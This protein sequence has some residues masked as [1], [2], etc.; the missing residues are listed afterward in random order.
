MKIKLKPLQPQ[1]IEPVLTLLEA[2]HLE[3][4][5]EARGHSFDAKSV[6]LNLVQ[7]SRAPRAWLRVA[8]MGAQRV[9]VG[10]LML[11]PS[12][13]D[14]RNLQAVELTWHSDPKLAPA[15]RCRI[16]RAIYDGME[17]WARS[18]RAFT[19]HFSIT[20]EADGVQ[21]FLVRR[22]FSLRENL[23]NKRLNYGT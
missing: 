10:A 2:F 13:T 8:W 9:G 7:L 6:C 11:V 19:M 23:F 12:L 14:G 17:T 21:R 1:D 4:G 20:P 3:M 15:L 5:F 18:V 16:M 22:G